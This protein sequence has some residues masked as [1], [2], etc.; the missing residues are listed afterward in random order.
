MEKLG[1][2]SQ[3]RPR[4]FS[5]QAEGCAPIVRAFEAGENSAAE[6]R[7]AHTLAA[8]LRVPKAIGDFLI[9]KILRQSNGG[10]IAVSD[11]EMIRVAGEVASSEGLFVAPE[12][13]A[14]FAALRSL[15]SSGKIS[16]DESVVIFNTGSGIK[17]LD[18]YDA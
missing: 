10:A 9:L 17:Y 1:W 11:E 3:K 18:C 4:M 8:G 16:P 7:D 6:F 13:A 15:L 14:C 2:I 12:G 5:V